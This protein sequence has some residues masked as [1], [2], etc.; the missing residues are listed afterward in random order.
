MLN[1]AIILVD[2]GKDVK[3]YC[4]IKNGAMPLFSDLR[5]NGGR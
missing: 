1:C 4:L 5:R 3:K 2:R